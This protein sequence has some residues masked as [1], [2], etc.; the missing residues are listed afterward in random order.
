MYP[1]VR[2]L[3]DEC[4]D[5]GYYERKRGSLV[6][7]NEIVLK[8]KQAIHELE[9]QGELATQLAIVRMLGMPAQ[10]LMSYPMVKT[11]LSQ[12]EPP[13]HLLSRRE[14]KLL[15][16][17]E[18]AIQQLKAHGQPFSLRKLCKLTGHAKETLKNCPKVKAM[19][20]HYSECKRDLHMTRKQLREVEAV[21]G[22][23]L[24]LA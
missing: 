17:I 24:T 16:E 23:L 18:A 15:E 2:A 8:V 21:I 4:I 11:L 5:E 19:L 7:S 1:R 20:Q 9:T 10:N 14:E 13:E 6:R 3:L 12:Y 22:Q